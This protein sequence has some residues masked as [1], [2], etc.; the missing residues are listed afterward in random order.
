MIRNMRSSKPPA[1]KSAENNGDTVVVT[2]AEWRLKI[3]DSGENLYVFGGGER[4]D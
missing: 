3:T 4:G 2:V 1:E